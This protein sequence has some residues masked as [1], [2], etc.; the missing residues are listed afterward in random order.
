MKNK[1]V[2]FGSSRLP[3]RFWKNVK[4]DKSGCWN[5]TAGLGNGYSS[6]WIDGETRNGHRVIYEA[7]ISP[8][9]TE[10]H[11]DHLCRNRRCVNVEHLEPVTLSENVL[12]GVGVTAENSR[13]E[14]C[15][16]GHAYDVNYSDGR[17]GCRQCNCDRQRKYR[18]KKMEE[19]NV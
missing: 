11:L 17:R 15:P 13:K 16:R 2:A 14:N 19:I 3:L 10:I 8:L 7:F 1:A 12:R 5:W 18:T 6:F 4:I 9:G